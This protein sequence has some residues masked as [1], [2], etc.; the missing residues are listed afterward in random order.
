MGFQEKD[1]A[2]GGE[3]V[4]V[5]VTNRFK[6]YRRDVYDAEMA[7]EDDDRVD[8]LTRIGRATSGG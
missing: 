1:L 8:P 6:L 3:A 4:F 5:G 2:N 7:K